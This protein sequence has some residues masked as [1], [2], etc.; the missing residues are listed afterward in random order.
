MFENY[1]KNIEIGEDALN[2]EMKR[3]RID[4][5]AN[6]LN[7]HIESNHDILRKVERKLYIGPMDPGQLT[8]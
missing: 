5:K 7:G 3:A 8:D 6:M 1:K 2:P 4:H